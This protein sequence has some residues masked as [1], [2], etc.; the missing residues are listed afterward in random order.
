ML[1]NIEFAITITNFTHTTRTPH[2]PQNSLAPETHN[3]GKILLLCD[4]MYR[5]YDAIAIHIFNSFKMIPRVCNR[6]I[7]LFFFR[8]DQV[9]SARPTTWNRCLHK[10]YSTN[11]V[12]VFVVVLRQQQK[13]EKPNLI[14]WLIYNQTQM[15]APRTYTGKKIGTKALLN[16]NGYEWKGD[17]QIK[18]CKSAIGTQYNTTPYTSSRSEWARQ[19]NKWKRQLKRKIRQNG[20]V[21]ERE[22]RFEKW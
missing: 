2:A 11:I 9:D 3:N 14:Y 19:T 20:T 7:E 10:I 6:E 1:A 22:A 8:S 5:P 17:R 16:W 21:H 4:E 12:N 13:Y 15:N 18:N